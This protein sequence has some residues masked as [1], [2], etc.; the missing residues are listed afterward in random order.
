MTSLFLANYFLRRYS[1]AL[2]KAILGFSRQAVSR[3]MSHNWPGNV[4]ELCN[5]VKHAALM[6]CHGQVVE[7][8]NLPSAFH[9]GE[10]AALLAPA[11][12]RLLDQERQLILHTLEQVNW[13]KYQAA[14]VLGIARSTLYGKIEQFGLEPPQP[15]LAPSRA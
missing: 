6:W 3:L 7:M 15:Q 9:Y 12:G 8:E 4:H 11:P 13:H 14:K 5:V 10:L 1:E 2:G